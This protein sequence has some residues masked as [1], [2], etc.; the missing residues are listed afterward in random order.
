MT[1]IYIIE[2]PRYKIDDLRII[3][4][5]LNLILETEIKKMKEYITELKLEYEQQNNKLNEI[6]EKTENSLQEYE[7]L[8]YEINTIK[9]NLISKGEKIT[10]AVLKKILETNSPN[11]EIFNT[12][13]ILYIIIKNNIAE[14]TNHKTTLNENTISWKLIQNNFTY[15]SILLL[16][17]YISELT[18]M[19]L[20]K[21]MTKKAT[22]IIS[23]YT[24]SQ[25]QIQSEFSIII[26]FLKLFL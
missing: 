14:D 3:Y 22:M 6:V 7:L 10:S 24:N 4:K 13:K 9:K 26:D 11:L 21:E 20:S 23:E 15:K 8:Y 2:S 5:N 19:N 1:F 25:N 16:L 17:S 12:L 18:S